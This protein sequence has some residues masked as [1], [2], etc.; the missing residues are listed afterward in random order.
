MNVCSVHR[1]S[2]SGAACAGLQPPVFLN[3]GLFEWSIQHQDGTTDNSA[4]LRQV[5]EEDRKW[6]LEALE[7]QQE[8][9]VKRMKTIKT[10]LDDRDDSEEQ[11]LQL[12][13][14][15]ASLPLL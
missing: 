15:C 1:G 7:S 4:Q 12:C 8:D 2:F 9:L 5:S 10:A 11:V 14:H 6:F 13:R 3:A